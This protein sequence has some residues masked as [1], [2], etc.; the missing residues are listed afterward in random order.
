LTHLVT[1]AK[2]GVQTRNKKGWAPAFAGV[3]DEAGPTMT[4]HSFVNRIA[5]TSLRFWRRAGIF[6]A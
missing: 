1:P 3:T 2:A 4:I 5:H 6:D